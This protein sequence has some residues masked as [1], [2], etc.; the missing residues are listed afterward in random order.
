M[1]NLKLLTALGT[2]TLLTACGGAGGG[3]VV[4]SANPTGGSGSSAS[5]PTPG[6]PPN[7][8]VAITGTLVYLDTSSTGNTGIRLE[9]TSGTFNPITGAVSITGSGGFSFADSDGPSGGNWVSGEQT[10][11]LFD[12]F[13]GQVFSY[14]VLAVTSDQT[15]PST[16]LS[17][18]LLGYATSASQMPTG[19][20]ASYNGY[21]GTAVSDGYTSEGTSVVSVNFGAGTADVTMTQTDFFD[22]N[23]ATTTDTVFG[24]DEV[25][26]SGMTISG[27]VLQNGT[28]GLSLNGSPLSLSGVP[29]SAG[30]NFYGWDDSLGA[31]DEVAGVALIDGTNLY[32]LYAI[33]FFIAD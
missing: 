33:A 2:A 28:V 12:T 1:Q 32:D 4:V 11:Q 30:G 16:N 8:D 21:S 27:S 22:N 26:I 20:Q 31:P 7:A 19:G 17:L 9:T 15:G 14:A 18:G 3:A 10:A 5:Y 29:T 25:T 6:S 23:G 24:F 13:N